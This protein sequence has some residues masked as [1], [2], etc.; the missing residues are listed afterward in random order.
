MIDTFNDPN[1][2]KHVKASFRTKSITVSQPHVITKKDVNSNINGLLSTGVESTAKTRRP[3]PRS[4]LKNDRISS[5]SKS[6][7]LS[8]NLE[9]VE[10]HHRN[11]LFS[12]TSNHTSSAC[13]NVKLAVRNDKSKVVYATCKQCLITAN[14][15]ECVLKYEL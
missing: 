2:N 1:T 6:S 14:H 10:V 4:N 3:H 5:V 9:K 12:K 11:L 13:N 8:N 15:D 7:C